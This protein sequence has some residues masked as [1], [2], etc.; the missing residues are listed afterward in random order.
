MQRYV[1]FL[2][3]C[4]IASF[5]GVATAAEQKDSLLTDSI[6]LS[7]H[8]LDSIR[9]TPLPE[10]KGLMGWLKRN[11]SGSEITEQNPF[12]YSVVAGP[13][14]SSSASFSIALGVLGRY[15]WDL[16]D[17]DLQL[18]QV[19][20]V[21]QVSLKGMISA[22]VLGQNYLRNDRWRWH[23]ELRWQRQPMD[24]WG[25]GYEQGRYAQ[26]EEYNRHH[27][28]F[29]TELMMRVARKTYLGV[30][31][32]LKHTDASN[33]SEHEKIGC[34]NYKIFAAGIGPTLQVDMR[35]N[36]SNASRG[37]FL[38]L[39]NVFFPRHVNNYAFSRTDF[40]V[41]AY[42]PLWRGA[43]GCFE[44][45]S[46]FNYGD[47]V[48][49]TMLAQVAENGSRMRGYYEG[50]Y[51]DRN[52]IEGQVELR[53][54]VWK[55]FGVVAFAGAANVFPYFTHFQWRHTLPNFGAGIRYRFKGTVLRL[56]F[57]F[58]QNN[59]GFVFNVNEAF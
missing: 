17:P 11:F 12:N 20:A 45:H 27:I 18:S 44:V 29:D 14:Y 41:S 33:L 2:F 7:Q 39:D 38:R 25:I 23:Y 8:R 28:L 42:H 21:A 34:Q 1:K 3:I 57:G 10:R 47:N 15:S 9:I 55:N 35:D 36:S 59:P 19:S 16:K 52:I 31:L 46:L 51:T 26:K 24:I 49:W 43:V 4:L 6:L 56:D 58:T 30:N 53:Q 22:K 48:P 37:W 32:L 40:V 5:G 54:H 13:Y 50:R